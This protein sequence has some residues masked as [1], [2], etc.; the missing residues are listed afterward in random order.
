MTIKVNLNLCLNPTLWDVA[1]HHR[2]VA[3]VDE[4]SNGHVPAG[5]PPFAR[6]AAL[7]PLQV[8]DVDGSVRFLHH[9]DRKV[10]RRR[11]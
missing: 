1:A 4:V 9:G 3:L 6:V 8:V 5:R 7:F 11:T 2:H 10:G